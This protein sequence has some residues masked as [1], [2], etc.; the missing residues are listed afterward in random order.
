MKGIF[1]AA[2]ASTVLASSPVGKVIQLIDELKA[3]VSADLKNEAGLMEEYTSFCDDEQTQKG[4]AIK[5]ATR[6]IEELEAIIESTTSKITNLKSIIEESGAAAASK[7]QELHEATEVRNSENKDFQAAE[8][9]LVESIDTLAR[10]AVIIKRELSFV[11][12]KGTNNMTKKLGALAQA[13]S[14]IV[15]AAWVNPSSKKAV[16]AFLDD[17]LSLTQQPQAHVKN[18]ES[19][20]GGIVTALEDMKD[21]AEEN[22]N[23]LRREETK[24]RH[25]FELLKQGIMDQVATIE[26]QIATSKSA[27]SSSSEALGKAEGDLSKT[28]AVKNA[29][30]EYVKNLVQE[31]N[32]KAAEWSE[33]QNAANAEMAAL[34]KGSEILTAKFSFAQ[35]K[36]QT[37]TSDAI[38]ARDRVSSM[39]KKMARRYNS[40]ALMQA[41]S[42]AAK[43]PFVKIRGLIENMIT[44]LE[45]EAQEEATQEA[46]CQEENTKSAKSRDQKS[47]RVDKI[48]A[49]ID[50]AKASKDALKNDIAQL[51]QE[52]NQTAKAVQE[53][54]ALRQKEKE[55]YL[56]ASKDFK[57]SSE[58]I[59]QALVVLKE[60]YRGESFV[61]QPEFGSARGDAGHS[62]IEIL[63]TAESDFSRLLAEAETDETESQESF[64]KF[65]QES[66]V[67]KATKEA[68]VKAKTS[69]IKSIEVALSHQAEDME[70]VSKELDAV[71]EYIEKLKPQ[72]ESKAMSYEERKARRDAEVA[73][74]KD[75][76]QI[77]EGEDVALLQ[78]RSRKFMA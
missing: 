71:L 68:S 32:Q 25:A 41:A 31:C 74:L 16:Q 67:S 13:L 50:E 64:E 55:D 78:T 28:E 18:Y 35:V 11:Q 21:K 26:K 58:A 47:A 1:V 42:E 23:Q 7:S 61:Q 9:E 77:L 20:S 34:A 52:L 62:I 8:K 70:S 54:T 27:L 69:E 53:A 51:Q 12:G 36:V 57:E 56:K 39:L 76:L 5:T 48:Q 59:T 3:K 30:E 33:R 60:F 43:D 17:D 72:C 37:R 40:F 4:F 45:K 49:R 75:A 63:E 6:E 73:G 46:F 19:K 14:S 15:D 29:D 10:A 38:D 44:K 65:T 24:S 2:A 66:K 22:L